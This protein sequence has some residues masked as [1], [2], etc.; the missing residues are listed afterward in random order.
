MTEVVSELRRGLH[1]RTLVSTS[2]GLAFA[3][4]QYLAVASLLTVVAGKYAWLAVLV[5]GV[6]VLLAW[7][8]FS[9]LCGIFPTAAA[10][11]R[12]M[13]A[14]M[15]DEAALTITFTYMSSIVLV[16]AADAYIVGSAIASAL[17]EPGWV[18][19]G[20]IAL[21]LG[22]ATFA[23]LKGV[24]VAGAVQDVAT[25]IIL[26]VTAVIAVIACFHTTSPVAHALELTRPVGVGGFVQAVALGI[27]L[28]SA[29][30]WV[31]TSA[32]EVLDVR[33][34]PKAML[35]S[36][37][38]LA[39]ICAA[40]TYGM[41]KLLNA[42]EIGSAFPQL[43]L[44]RHALGA[45]G[46]WTMAGITALT[47]LDTFNGG[48][49]TASRFIYAAAREG[50]LP[51]KAARLNNNAVP[52]VPVIALAIASLLVSVAV[53]LTHSWQVILSV[54]AALESMIFAVAGLCVLR[55]RKRL[56]DVERPF[57][58]RAPRTFT[59]AGIVI[60]GFLSLT[61]GLSVDNKFDARPLVILLVV[62]GI[63]AGY[64]LGYIPKLQAAEAARAAAAPQRRRPVANTDS[65]ES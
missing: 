18:V 42:D 49:I 25:Y 41:A 45:F 58:M 28:F 53:S 14:S 56:P 32:E 57:R 17:N 11:R 15:R 2:T 46:Y 7:A 26:G 62:G 30:E 6:L 13:Q 54:G 37:G 40:L 12:Y 63:C 22:I 31:T 61:A 51:H 34:I 64:V 16:M 60:F 65:K 50:A 27:L 38:I 29:F 21:M 4:I 59:I 35:I 9:E 23:N 43:A 44:G 20:Y 8:F 48:F 36:V 3:A 39:A 10:I 52:W 47:A 24:T 5:A 19:S 1:F 33:Q 55:L